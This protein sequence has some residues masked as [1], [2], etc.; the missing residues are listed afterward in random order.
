V[1]EKV[2]NW[3]NGIRELGSGIWKTNG[4]GNEIG[5]PLRTLYIP[6]RDHSL[7]IPFTCLTK[8]AFLSKFLNFTITK[9]NRCANGAACCFGAFISNLIPRAGKTAVF[10]VPGKCWIPDLEPG[11]GKRVSTAFAG[12]IL[13]LLYKMAWYCLSST[14]DSW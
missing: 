9:S 11:M 14:L 13:H 10:I 8:P 12:L 3:T 2:E 7:F 4:P 5:T 1:A 6:S